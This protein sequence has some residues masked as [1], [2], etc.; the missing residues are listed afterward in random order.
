MSHV[1]KYLKSFYIGDVSKEK[2]DNI[3]DDQALKEDFEQ[4]RQKF[5]SKV[6]SFF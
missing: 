2:E 1:Q 5:I 6:N 4:L 3:D